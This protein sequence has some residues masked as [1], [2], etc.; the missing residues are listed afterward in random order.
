MG[1][2]GQDVETKQPA[3]APEARERACLDLADPLLAE[4]V[5]SR[6]LRE[7]LRLAVEPKPG[8]DDGALAV[9]QEIEELVDAVLDGLAGRGSLGVRRGGIGEELLER[10]IPVL[11]HGRVD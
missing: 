6:H 9:G 2:P 10:Y 5:P 1:L 7:R 4:P 8:A 3:G 11:T